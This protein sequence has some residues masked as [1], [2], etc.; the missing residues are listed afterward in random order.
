MKIGNIDLKNCLL[1]LWENKIETTGV[2]TMRPESAGSTYNI[3]I[4]CFATNVKCM[5]EIIRKINSW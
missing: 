1:H 5:T 3:T 2:D 4:K